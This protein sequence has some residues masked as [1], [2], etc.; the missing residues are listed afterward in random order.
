MDTTS[1]QS[2]ALAVPPPGVRQPARFRAN[3]PASGGLEAGTW[4]AAAGFMSLPRHHPP[5]VREYHCVSKCVDDQHLL[6]PTAETTFIIARVWEMA[7]AKYDFTLCALVGMNN[8][9]HDHIRPGATPLPRIQQFVKSQ[10]ARRMNRV[11]GRSGAFWMRRYDDTAILDAEASSNSVH[12]LHANPVRAS[13]SEHADSWIGTSSHRAFI[14]GRDS[15]TA[16]WFDERS[17]ARAGSD[18]ARKDEFV[19][20]AT[21]RIGAPIAFD[22]LSEAEREALRASM[23]ARMEAEEQAATSARVM[24]GRSPPRPESAARVDPRS[25]PERPKRVARPDRRE[26]RMVRAAG[27]ESLVE[28][29]ADAYATKLP[30]YRRASEQYRRTGALC[31]FPAGMYPPWIPQ[32]FAVT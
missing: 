32:A 29:L 1:G 15:F 16:S 9:T 19:H 7:Q 21:V 12:Y 23:R 28:Q 11:L 10:I 4:G 5:E 3:S 13:L 14:E 2:V 8:H 18:P 20:T 31:A 22:G 26:S 25:R 30:V 24:E 17:W 27:D 6:T